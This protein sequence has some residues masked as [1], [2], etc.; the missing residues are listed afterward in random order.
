[1]NKISYED[2]RGWIN[3]MHFKIP[4]GCGIS[5]LLHGECGIHASCDKCVLERLDLCKPIISSWWGKLK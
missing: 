2:L 4:F 1:M 5:L 3:F